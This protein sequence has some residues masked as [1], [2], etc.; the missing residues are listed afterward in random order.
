M[1]YVGDR[2][3]VQLFSPGGIYQSQVRLL[4]EPRATGSNEV[5]GTSGLAV[6][7]AG[8]MYVIRNGIVGVDEYDPSGEL[9]QTLDEQGE[10]SYPE[11]PTPTLALDSAGDVFIDDSANGQH[12]IDEYD[13]MGAKLASFDAGMEGGLHG[14]AFG[15]RIGALY[16]VDTN[17]NATPT[18]AQV[19]VVRPP[20][21]A[22]FSPTGSELAR[23]LISEL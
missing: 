10:P 20:D 6:N 4:P 22:P 3:R 14:I 11:G 23:W 12:Q 9:L 2:N 13:S 7:A 1:V 18:I 8:D 5:G 19:R 17:S 15:D 16:V 21:P